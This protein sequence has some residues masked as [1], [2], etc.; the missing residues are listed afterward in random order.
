MKE[1]KYQ[2]GSKVRYLAFDTYPHE[3]TISESYLSPMSGH[4]CY[5]IIRTDGCFEHTMEPA[6]VS[7]E[8]DLMELLSL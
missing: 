1:P 2:D 6:I 3:G 7:V 8:L 5:T 4:Y